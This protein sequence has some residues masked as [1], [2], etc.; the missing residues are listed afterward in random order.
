MLA[1]SC[2][3]N[4][5]LT[6]GSGGDILA[7]PVEVEINQRVIRRLLTTPGD[8]VWQPTYGAGLGTFVGAP[9]FPDVVKDII[10]SQLGQETLIQS[11]PTPSV[12]IAGPISS[13]VSTTSVTIDFKVNG[14]GTNTT[15]SLVINEG[16]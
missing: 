12:T 4:S 11:S 10:L 16:S 1:I 6:L 9:F 14:S 15:N 7:A 3:W 2:D 5:D 13:A 8:Y